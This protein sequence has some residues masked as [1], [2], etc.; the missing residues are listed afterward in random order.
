MSHFMAV[1]TGSPGDMDAWKA[2][3]ADTRAQRERDGI[4]A[5]HK[6]GQ[7][8]AASIVDMGGPLGKT[9]RVTKD[10]IADARNALTAYTVARAQSQEAAAKL[11]ENHPH[12]TIFPGDGVEVMPILDIP[13]G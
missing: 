6:W 11:F 8:H 9:R 12:F 13:P 3:D 5:W 4:A 2:L 7:D 10:G 1:F